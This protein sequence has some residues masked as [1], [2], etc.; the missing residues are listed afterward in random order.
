MTC[1]MTRRRPGW[2]EFAMACAA[3]TG[4][5]FVACCWLLGQVAGEFI[6]H[7]WTVRAGVAR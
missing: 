4:A 1:S 7:W 6:G 3:L 5:G 2:R